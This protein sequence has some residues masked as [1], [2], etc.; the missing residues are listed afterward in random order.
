MPKTE[1]LKVKPAATTAPKDIVPGAAP[2]QF[3]ASSTPEGGI[4]LFKN[5]PGRS[6]Y[7]FA[8][9]QG[10][11]HIDVV[12]SDTFGGVYRANNIVTVPP[13]LSPMAREKFWRRLQLAVAAVIDA[14]LVAIEDGGD[15]E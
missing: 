3:A 13:C 11:G 1:I 9:P 2:N 10:A 12:W 15:D 4:V 14:A 6:D 7:D 5:A 8:T